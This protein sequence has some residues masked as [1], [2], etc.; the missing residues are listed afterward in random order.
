[1]PAFSHELP[2]L[3]HNEIVGWQAADRA[4]PLQ[5][6]VPRRL[7]PASADPPADRADARPDRGRGAPPPSGSRASGE[8]ATERLLSLVLL[9]DLVSLYLAVLRGVDPRPGADD[10]PAQERAGGR[11][12]A[13]ARAVPS[14]A[15]SRAA[16]RAA[17]R[18][19]RAA[20]RPCRRRRGRSRCRSSRPSACVRPSAARCVG[21]SR[22]DALSH[23]RR[24]PAPTA[25]PAAPRARRRRCGPTTSCGARRLG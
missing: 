7:R 1:M 21:N 22:A 18:R 16:R 23:A 6:G 11:L 14:A 9:G 4:R 2:E 12:S 20:P 10:R 5:R 17:G 24:R 15:R 25:R 13:R 19:P 8:T 3:D